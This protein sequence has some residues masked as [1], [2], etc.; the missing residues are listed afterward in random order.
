MVFFSYLCSEDPNQLVI[1]VIGH[2]YSSRFQR[3]VLVD[4]PQK[5]LQGQT[6]EN[7]HTGLHTA[8]SL[9]I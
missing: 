8:I 5:S 6:A 4:N 1:L 7:L 9:Y 3:C 2:V